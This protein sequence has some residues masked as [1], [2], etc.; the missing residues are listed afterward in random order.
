MTDEVMTTFWLTFNDPDAPSDKRFLGVAILDIDES[1]RQA[2]VPEIVRKTHAFD[3]LITKWHGTKFSFDHR[4]KVEDWLTDLHYL[5][6]RLFYCTDD[7]PPDV[8]E[9]LAR[10]N[11]DVEKEYAIYGHTYAA[12]AHALTNKLMDPRTS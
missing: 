8:V 5:S 4:V 12:A 1:R 3:Y 7:M 11:L 6:G 10:L 9:L 2:S